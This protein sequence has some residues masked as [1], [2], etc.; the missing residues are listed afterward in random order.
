M[1]LKGRV[2]IVTGAAGGLGRAIALELVHEGMNVVAVDLAQDPMDVLV[3]EAEGFGADVLAMTADV[4]SSEST[5]RMAR[6]T[7]DRFGRIDVLVNNAGV[8]VAAPFVEMKR[9]DWDRIIGVNL[10]GVFNCCKA[11]VPSMIQRKTG[12]IVNISSVAGKRA[13]PLIS[14]YSASKFGVIG[15]TQALAL[16]L[17]EYDITV[18]AVCPG[19]IETA[20]WKD[21]L[22]PALSPLLGVGAEEVFHTFIETNVPLKRPQ[23]PEDIAQC[24]VFLCKADNITGAAINV[25]G[26]HTMV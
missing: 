19:F 3:K 4:T 8:I 13:A 1:E 20:M 25:D 17:G 22:N 26:G 12:R 11:V 9:A 7:L 23:S 14:A 2:G 15:L 6:K 18:N 5:E 24:V 10:G 21:H 16:E